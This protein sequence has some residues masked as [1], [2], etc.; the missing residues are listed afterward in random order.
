M[1]NSI[2]VNVKTI[3]FKLSPRL[4]FVLRE[5]YDTAKLRLSGEIGRIIT[6]SGSLDSDDSVFD[7]AHQYIRPFQI[8]S[9]IIGLIEFFNKHQPGIL[10]EVGTANGGTHFLIRRLCPSIRLSIAVDIDIRNCSLIDRITDTESSHYIMGKSTSATTLDKVRKILGR[11]RKLDV[12]FLDGDHSYEGVKSDFLA[13][14]GF[15]RPGGLIVFHDIVLDHGQRFGKKTE[16][17]TGGVPRFFEDIKHDYQHYEFV[18]N[19]E[20][21][22]YGIGVIVAA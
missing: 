6:E 9:E 3:L 2:I 1:A 4:Y 19:P 14:R 22:G 20:Q 17:F 5:T 12:L 16:S 15:V 18:E 8:K 7:F 11:Q 21:D 13:Y 10:L